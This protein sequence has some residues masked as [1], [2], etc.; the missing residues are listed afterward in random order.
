MTSTIP[1]HPNP[2][3]QFLGALPELSRVADDLHRALRPA[4]TQGRD[5]DRSFAE[6]ALARRPDGGARC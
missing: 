5:Q 1:P 6:A 2:S 3:W 4:M